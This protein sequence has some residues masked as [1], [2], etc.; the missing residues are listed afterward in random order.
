M[1]FKGLNAS[2]SKGGSV[3]SAVGPS[4]RGDVFRAA[5]LAERRDFLS[6]L[7]DCCDRQRRRGGRLAVL[8]VDLDRFKQINVAFG[9]DLGDAV[10]H[11]VGQR[12]ASISDAVIAS[13]L[14][15]DEF[16]LVVPVADAA[17]AL[18]IACAVR[19]G[20]GAPLRLEDGPTVRVHGSVGVSLFPDHGEDAA[21][22][23]HRA[24]LAAYHAKTSSPD[25][26]VVFSPALE[27]GP[28]ER[29]RLLLALHQALEGEEFT[30]ALQPKVTLADRRYAGAEVLVR[31]SSPLL[32][33][34]PPDLFVPVAEDAGLIQGLG[35][36]VL[37]QA[38]RGLG[39]GDITG[40][41]ARRIAINVSA[42]QL[43]HEQFP[44]RF[45]HRLEQA[46]VPGEVIEVEVTESALLASTAVAASRL[47]ALR[48]M[49]IAIT[50][51]DFGTGYSSFSH[52]KHLPIDAL[53][54][55]PEFIADIGSDAAAA[56]L[57]AAMVA[58][59]RSLNLRVVAEGVETEDQA[60]FLTGLGCT[61]GQGY[62]FG[63]PMAPPD[64]AR[65]LK[66]HDAR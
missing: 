5:V 4:A 2:L 42:A 66:D 48:T 34:V 40:D 52:L 63:R 25:H 6:Q 37:A 64:F 24:D 8:C 17:A 7:Q 35:D 29:Q 38:T 21:S 50:L 46:G 11:A 3:A 47:E 31:W 30:L 55:A 57:L 19:D 59:A 45:R 65:W 51:D 16:V 36:W 49:G 14:A 58:L 33:D 43:Q 62:L 56:R 22:L 20:L 41:P 13:H 27:Q 18:A 53:K 23:F 28:R 44:D 12:L 61:E 15:G 60:S 26:C 39:A 54:I 9:H 1:A 32:G 10:L